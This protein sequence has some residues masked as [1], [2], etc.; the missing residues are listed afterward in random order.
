M[1][2]EKIFDYTRENNI[3]DIHLLEAI[4]FKKKM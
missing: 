3:S 4:S 1:D 2:I